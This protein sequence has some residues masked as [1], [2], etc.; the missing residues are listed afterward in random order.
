[1]RYYTAL[2]PLRIDFALPVQRRTGAGVVDPDESFQVYV[3]LGQAF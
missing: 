3:G 1:L 2:G